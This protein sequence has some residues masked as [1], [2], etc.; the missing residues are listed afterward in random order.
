MAEMEITSNSVNRWL[1]DR[2]IVRLFVA[3][4]L[5]SGLQLSANG[6]H[7]LMIAAAII[8]GGATFSRWRYLTST[9]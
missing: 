8:V 6:P 5:G 9:P 3:L 7:W 1:D 4:G 2:P